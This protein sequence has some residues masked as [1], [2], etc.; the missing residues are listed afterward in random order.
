M[1]GW[2]P[3]LLMA[4]GIAAFG[5]SWVALAA[6]ARDGTFGASGPALAWVHL[7]ALGWI[8][9][10]ALAVL[11]HAVPGFLDVD[12]SGP[13]AIVARACSAVFPFAALGLVA[14]FL[15]ASPATLAIAG[16]VVLAAIA[17]Y[18]A[19][20]FAPL[21]AAMGGD[22]VRRAVARA[23][24]ATL[25]LLVL[26]AILGVTFAYALDGI[27]PPTMLAGAPQAHALLGIGGWLTLL[28]AGVS[29]R[30]MGP[31]AGA[32][33]RFRAL[34]V[35]ASSALLAGTLVA[36]AG[37][38]MANA[39]ALFTGC[40]LLT[41]G[42]LAYAAD[43][44]DV[45]RRATV[46]HRAPQAFMAFAALWAV[47]ATL[48]LFAGAADASH[49]SAAV[50]AALIG[51]IGGAV[52]AHVHHIGVRVLLT[53]VRGEEDETRPWRV[54]APPLTWI[55]FGAYQAAAVLGTAGAYLGDGRAIAFAAGAGLLAFAALALN[56]ARAVALARA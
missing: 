13:S 7:V 31:I 30:T 20:V 50:Y 40:A 53:S 22:G 27:A 19:A 54:L 43:V 29:A 15:F 6:V 1:R 49:A 26:T 25:C 46:P 3:P 10:I 11:L 47:V 14:G 12:W 38:W 17:A 41:A 5:A 9:T 51:W 56:G 48:L 16:S 8:T 42:A 45:L 24:A 23:F 55:T 32:R 35:G 52:L 44:A 4:L 34:H 18:V 36:A 33:P 28:V 39:P 2:I 37:A 21:H